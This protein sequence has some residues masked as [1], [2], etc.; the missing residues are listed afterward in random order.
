MPLT[1]AL[2]KIAKARPPAWGIRAEDCISDL[3]FAP[4]GHT[5]LATSLSGQLLC[6]DVASGKPRWQAMA[7]PLGAL[8]VDHHPSAALIA[9]GGQDGTVKIWEANKGALLRTVPLNPKLWM[10]HGAWSHDGAFLAASGGR[11]VFFLDQQGKQIGKTADHPHTVLC[12]DWHPSKSELCSGTNGGTWIFTP[13]QAEPRESMPWGSAALVI[14]YSPNGRFIAVGNQD[15]TLH[16]W[17]EGATKQEDHLRMAGY[18]TKI[19]ELSWRCDSSR[20][21]TG[22]GYNVITWNFSGRGPAGSIPAE[23]TSHSEF[24]TALASH[25]SNPELCASTA[26]D[27]FLFLWDDRKPDPIWLRVLPDTPASHLAWHPSGE[28]LAA[29]CEGGEVCLYKIRV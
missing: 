1:A 16:A 25:P 2:E 8:W 23:K 3:Q 17:P 12:L 24:I 5:L 21:T 27:H 20:L 19:R 9:T 6:L 22:G 14:R 7:H 18:A 28:S 29:G 13:D 11:N 26:K 4:H 15:Q 10:E